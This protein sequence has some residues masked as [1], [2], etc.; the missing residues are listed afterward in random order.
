MTE[1]LSDVFV[2]VAK[3]GFPIDT[4]IEPV[5]RQPVLAGDAVAGN[6]AILLA[7]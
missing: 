5:Y 4:L 6:M 2:V 3:R 1:I 7:R